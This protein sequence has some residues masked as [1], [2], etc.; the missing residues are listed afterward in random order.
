[1]KKRIRLITLRVRE[2]ANVWRS[3]PGIGESADRNPLKKGGL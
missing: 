1:M 3:G 2:S